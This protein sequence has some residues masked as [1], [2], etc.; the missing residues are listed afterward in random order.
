[1]KAINKNDFLVFL[2]I[3][4]SGFPLLYNAD[5]IVVSSYLTTL[6]LSLGF[7]LNNSQRSL[8]KILPIY[9]IGFAI[10]FSLQMLFLDHFSVLKLLSF[11][12]KATFVILILHVVGISFYHTYI[13]IILFF[14]KLSFLFYVPIVLIPQFKSF[15]QKIAITHPTALL[16]GLPLKNLIVFN[17]NFG[18]ISDTI[19]RNSGPFWEPG[20][21]AGFL[22][23]AIF[24]NT[25]IE[26][27][28]WNKKNIILMI[29]V[30]TTF[31]TSGL[32]ALMIMIIFSMVYIQKKSIVLLGFIPL[33]LFFLYYTFNNLDVLGDK[34]QREI[35]FASND[36][37]EGNNR[38]KSFVVDIND[39]TTSPYYGLGLDDRTRYI[40]Y[41]INGV[42]NRNNGISDYLVRFGLIG[43]LIYFFSMFKG[44]KNLLSY[45]G[46]NK[47]LRY[48]FILLI[49]IIGFSELYFRLP[50]FMA[51]SLTPFV[52]NFRA[53]KNSIV[54]KIKFNLK[55]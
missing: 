26:K 18:R 28:I 19:I 22:I 27:S 11:Y 1:M 25:I 16:N 3:A 12:I 51:L 40:D 48:L 41:D 20:A 13:K 29:G 9:L 4:N 39:F 21:F 34:I 44:I 50:F 55:F 14:T 23:V 30:I 2:L 6:L 53:K 52:I 33:F 37:I 5:Y 17:L 7:Y 46:A 35:Y 36:V 15:L 32:I 31:S 24:F 47:N 45:Y 43:F 8:K 49:F 54:N 38:I 42:S 10:I